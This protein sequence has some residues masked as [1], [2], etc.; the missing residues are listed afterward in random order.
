MLKIGVFPFLI[1][2]SY[3]LFF[4]YILIYSYD[5]DKN[6]SFVNCNY[7]FPIILKFSV[8]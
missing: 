4:I 6:Q 8:F 5:E 2:S 7:I 3:I 1:C